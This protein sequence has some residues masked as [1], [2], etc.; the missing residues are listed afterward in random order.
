MVSVGFVPERLR[1]TV[2]LVVRA[3]E[4]AHDVRHGHVLFLS[5]R[6][7]FR[8]L[9]WGDVVEDVAGP[10]LDSH[11]HHF[12]SRM[13]RERIRATTSGPYSI[14]AGLCA[15]AAPAA[16]VDLVAAPVGFQLPRVA[17]GLEVGALAFELADAE[18]A[19]AEPDRLNVGDVHR[20]RRSRTCAGSGGVTLR[21]PAQ[22]DA[23]TPAL[24]RGQGAYSSIAASA[25]G[26]IPFS[27][28]QVDAWTGR[29][30]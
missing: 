30:E 28:I 14:S 9:R 7:Q 3:E 12:T 21:P 1:R 11:S 22:W 16:A 19:A 27:T 23:S 18:E 24:Q 4:A 29:V 20:P 25:G 26:L 5:Q 15:A 8:A 17:A 13:G 6:G 2:E 10:V